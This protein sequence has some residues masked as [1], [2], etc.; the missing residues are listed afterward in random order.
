MT[1]ANS[2]VAVALAVTELPA[3]TNQNLASPL[4]ISLMYLV[5]VQLHCHIESLQAFCFRTVAECR[6]THFRHCVRVEM[7]GP[8]SWGDI[9]ESDVETRI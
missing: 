3:T 4:E 8:A 2:Y 6:S 9:E 5:L 1:N 7:S